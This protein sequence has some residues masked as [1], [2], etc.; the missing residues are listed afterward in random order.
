VGE[1]HGKLSFALVPPIV[2]NAS[3]V[4]AKSAMK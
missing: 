2:Q 4:A 3:S 1:Q